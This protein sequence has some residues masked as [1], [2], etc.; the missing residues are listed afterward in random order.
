MLKQ[1]LVGLGIT[2]IGILSAV[3]TD[4]DI[5]ACVMVVPLG[6]YTLLTKKKIVD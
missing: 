2:V 5:T 6:I 1:R 3:V 4:G